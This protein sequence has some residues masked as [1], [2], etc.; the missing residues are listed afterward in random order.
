MLLKKRF[1]TRICLPTYPVSGSDH[2]TLIEESDSASATKFWGFPGTCEL[3]YVLA[4]TSSEIA[5]APASFT[6]KTLK[7]Y[8]VS[9]MRPGKDFLSWSPGVLTGL[10]CMLSVTAITC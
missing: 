1:S 3:G 6:A 9:G 4:V 5:P 10:N 8:F 7:R 2:V